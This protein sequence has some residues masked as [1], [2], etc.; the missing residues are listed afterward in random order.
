M[1]TFWVQTKVARLR[2]EVAEKRRNVEILESR[3]QQQMELDAEKSPAELLETVTS[4]KAALGEKEFA[5]EI[6]T[7]DNR[8]LREQLRAKNQK[9]RKAEE[10][11]AQLKANVAAPSVS[12]NGSPTPGWAQ[13]ISASDGPSVSRA[14]DFE[15]A[16]NGDHHADAMPD[17]A[18]DSL[19]MQLLSKVS[20]QRPQ[21]DSSYLSGLSDLLDAPAQ[22]F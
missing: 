5:V 18:Q 22:A 20:I 13:S 14:L 10:E 19:Q 1:R 11:I 7:A 17:S 16:A 6:A 9:L 8:I 2:E 15:G 3:I 12:Q 21:L 4:L